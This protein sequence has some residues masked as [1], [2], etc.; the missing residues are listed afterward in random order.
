MNN[1]SPQA[2]NHYYSVLFLKIFKLNKCF[3]LYKLIFLVY[4][5]IQNLLNPHQFKKKK[6]SV[7]I[8]GNHQSNS[9][10]IIISF[11]SI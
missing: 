3:I 2:H 11:Q 8:C 6:K 9:K 4:I 1:I 7:S 10:L 5:H